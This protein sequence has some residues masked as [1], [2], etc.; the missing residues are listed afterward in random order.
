MLYTVM[1]SLPLI[2][3]CSDTLKGRRF[4]SDGEV[5]ETEGIRFFF[6]IRKRSRCKGVSS[7]LKRRM[8]T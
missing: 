4:G 2:I 1:I 6:L 8:I 5:I 3:M 7:V